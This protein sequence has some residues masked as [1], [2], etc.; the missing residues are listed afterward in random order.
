VRRVDPRNN[1]RRPK[2]MAKTIFNTD[3]QRTPPVDYNKEASNPP[4][5]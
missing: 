4:L 1:A 5:I 3:R 2:M